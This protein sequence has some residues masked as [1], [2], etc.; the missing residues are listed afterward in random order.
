MPKI[1]EMQNVYF[2]YCRQKVLDNISFS[3]NTGD[4]VGLIGPNGGGKTTLIKLMMGLIKPNT[5]ST[6]LFGE[7]PVY[8]KD[9]NKIGYI[10]QRT[11]YFN[12]DF[13]AT[14]KEIVSLGVLG[15]KKIPRI[16]NSSDKDKI[17]MA[18]KTADVLQISHKLVGHLSGG[19]LQRVLLAKM[20]VGNPQIL[21]LDEPTS[22]LDYKSR[23]KFIDIIVS[24]NKEK[25]VTVIF[26]THDNTQISKYANVLLVTDTKLL[27]CGSPDEFCKSGDMAKYFGAFSQHIIC[28][29]HDDVNIE[30]LGLQKKT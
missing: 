27:F 5:G 29:R 22:A 21:F 24:L 4:F 28:R 12:F 14:V 20:L 25:N 30:K 16:I 15:Y 8:L 17:Y 3:L 18:M 1:A 9:K 13:P 26:I 10:P 7:N 11:G 2:D 19:Q 6:C 23:Q